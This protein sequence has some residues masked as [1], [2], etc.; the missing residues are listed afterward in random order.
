MKSI[1]IAARVLLVSAGLLLLP[2]SHASAG[3]YGDSLGKCFVES[4]TSAEKTALVRWMFIMMSLHPDVQDVG[5]VSPDQR[6]AATK[7]VARLFQDLLTEKCATE[8]KQALKY[9]GKSTMEA[10]FSLLGQ[11]AA[12]ELFSNPAVAEGLGELEKHIDEEKLKRLVENE[13]E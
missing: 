12:R 13:Q 3:P 5:S 2:L 1:S 6:N 11:V 4:T 9:E 10:S 8:A 7:D